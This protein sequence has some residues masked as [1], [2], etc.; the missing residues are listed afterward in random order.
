MKINMR[1]QQS[2]ISLYQSVAIDNKMVITMW[3]ETSHVRIWS[4]VLEI[5]LD[6]MQQV[7]EILLDDMQQD[8][9]YI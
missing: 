2:Q 5:L 1:M 3:L 4:V 8:T 7:L 9:K 6:D